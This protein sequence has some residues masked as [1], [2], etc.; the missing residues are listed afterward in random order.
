MDYKQILMTGVVLIISGY[1]GSA[2]SATIETLV[3][4]GPVSSAHAEFETECSECHAAF[5]KALQRDLCLSC[6][7]HE[8][9]LE[10]QASG[11]G[12]QG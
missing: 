10:D 1:Q 4:P 5:S 8:G 11:T 3:M 7:E 9:V 2:R 6:H 12:F